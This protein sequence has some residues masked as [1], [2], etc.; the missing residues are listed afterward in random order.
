M[1][2]KHTDLQEF[3]PGKKVCYV[4]TQGLEAGVGAL[5][6]LL[7]QLAHHQTTRQGLQLSIHHHQTLD[8]LLQVLQAYTNGDT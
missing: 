6:P 4:A 1:Q 5:G 2:Y 8:G 7:W 3:E